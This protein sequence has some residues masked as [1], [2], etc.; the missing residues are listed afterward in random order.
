M[1]RRPWYD[2]VIWLACILLIGAVA[3]TVLQPV[4]RD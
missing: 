4:F 2:Y 1:K 3:A